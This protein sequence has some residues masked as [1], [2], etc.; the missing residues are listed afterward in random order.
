MPIARGAPVVFADVDMDE[1]GSDGVNG[2]G[3]LFLLDV[4]AKRKN[5]NGLIFEDP[6]RNR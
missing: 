4:I 1:V 6:K 3:D 2:I 5:G